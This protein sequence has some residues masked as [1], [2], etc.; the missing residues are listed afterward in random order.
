MAKRRPGRWPSRRGAGAPP[1]TRRCT[2]RTGPRRAKRGPGHA[3]ALRAEGAERGVVGD[4]G[5][6]ARA[7]L[8]ARAQLVMQAL[9]LA[10]L[11]NLIVSA[12]EDLLRI[13]GAAWPLA[14]AKRASPPAGRVDEVEVLIARIRG[15]ACGQER[16][17]GEQEPGPGI[18]LDVAGH[19][20]LPSARRTCSYVSARIRSFR[21]LRNPAT[22]TQSKP[23]EHPA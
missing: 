22:L 7:R 1:R 10:I 14:I 2:R 13:G 20:S 12:L 23:R 19:D 9:A 18:S 17:R 16:R 21:L 5:V 15:R 3:P 6:D 4:G 8:G 11:I